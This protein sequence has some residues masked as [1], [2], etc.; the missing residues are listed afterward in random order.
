MNGNTTW[1]DCG[2]P[3]A[4]DGVRTV[5]VAGVPLA[6]FSTDQGLFALHDCCSHEQSPLSDGEVYDGTV[7]CAQHGAQFELATGKALS[8]PAVTGVKTF[9]VRCTNGHLFVGVTGDDSC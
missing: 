7:C 8:L 2:P 4:P 9:P 3:P 6:I 1:Y 5:T